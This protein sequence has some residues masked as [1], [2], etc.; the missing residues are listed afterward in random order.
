MTFICMPN[1]HLYYKFYSTKYNSQSTSTLFFIVTRMAC[2]RLKPFHFHC[3]HTNRPV[4]ASQHSHIR[5]S[6]ADRASGHLK[7]NP[8]FVVLTRTGQVGTSN[9]FHNIYIF[10]QHPQSQGFLNLNHQSSTSS[11]F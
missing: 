7:Y 4:D 5:R 11:I 10:A 8:T 2:G 9:T 6:H 3:P 1:V